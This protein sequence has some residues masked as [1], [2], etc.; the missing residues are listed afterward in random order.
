VERREKRVERR[1]WVERR[2]KRGRE[3]SGEEFYSDG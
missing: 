3:E 2:E 1:E